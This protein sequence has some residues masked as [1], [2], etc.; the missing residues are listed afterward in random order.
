MKKNDMKKI[1]LST[2]FWGFILWIFGFVLGILFFAILPK[3]MIGWAILPIGIVFSLFVLIKKIQREEF[4]CFIGLGIIWTIMAVLLDYVF[5]VR[6]FNATDYYRLDVYI[7]YISTF[8]LPLMVGF[9]R[10]KIKPSEK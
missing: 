2:L 3:E 7:Y 9:Y 4:R 6:L 1:L 10:F 8:T 5:L